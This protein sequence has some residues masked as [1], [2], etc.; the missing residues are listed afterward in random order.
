MPQT[1]NLT[2]SLATDPRASLEPWL[3]EI[4]THAR[5]L[6]AEHD[7]TVTGALTLVAADDVWN[8]IP[9]NLA[10]AAGVAQ[11]DPPQYRARPTWDQPNP[12]ANN[13][14]AAAVSL[15]K[16]EAARYADYSRA[17]SALISLGST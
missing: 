15:Y 12:H 16:L 3:E 8:I 2:K 6:C 17:S 7:V 9:A 10:N 4:E 1:L 5:N 13:A 11:G 14:A